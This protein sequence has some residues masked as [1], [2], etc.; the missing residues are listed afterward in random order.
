MCPL[1][2]STQVP[3]GASITP[4]K[5]LSVNPG[6]FP[7]PYPHHCAQATSVYSGSLPQFCG[8]PFTVQVPASWLN[9]LLAHD[10]LPENG[11]DM[12]YSRPASLH[13][14]ISRPDA[15]RSRP[16]MASPSAL[17]IRVQP[18]PSVV[19][20][21]PAGYLAEAPAG[22]P[23]DCDDTN[24]EISVALTV[25]RD[26]DQDGVGA[27]PGEVACTS[28]APPAGFALS[29]TDCDDTDASV[30]ASRVYTAVDLDGDGV[31]A[32]ALGTRCTA[33]SLT[34]PYYAAPAGNDCDDT[35]PTLTHFSVLYPDRDGD[36]VGAPP[37]QVPC[38]G[39]T[40]PPGFAPGGYD[41]DDGDPAGI[42]TE[43]LDDL[44]D[45][46]VLDG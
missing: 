15:P 20:S 1:V 17:V 31:T 21:L 40:T 45:L 22:R 8:V 18:P 4:G 12:M 24:P 2:E 14:I 41:E 46:V 25:F 32:P 30:W 6:P 34:P 42:E 37:R 13:L 7:Q 10:Q 3:G 5:N 11:G 39:A 38:L 23:L 16:T 43:D 35:D 28:G 29:G 33:G 27:G 19:M 9:L 44:L 36:G 26:A